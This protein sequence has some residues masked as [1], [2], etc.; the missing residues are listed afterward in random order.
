VVAAA[1]DIVDREGVDAA[2]IRRAADGIEE[3]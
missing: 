1:I 2:T 3:K